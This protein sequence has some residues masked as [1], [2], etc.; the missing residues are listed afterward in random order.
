MTIKLT[1]TMGPSRRKRVLDGVPIVRGLYAHKAPDRSKKSGLLNITHSDSGLSIMQYIP[2]DFLPMVIEQLSK[3]EWAVPSGTI[4]SSNKHFNLIRRTIQMLTS[5]QRSDKQENRIAED[6]QGKRQPASGSR[7]GYRRDVITPSFLVEAKTTE[8]TSYRL[9]DKDLAFLRDQAYEKGKIPVYI[10][11]LKGKSEVAVVPTDDVD[12][13]CLKAG[14]NKQISK[15]E[16]KS[17]SINLNTAQFVSDGGSITVTLPSGDYTVVG[18]EQF[19]EMAKVG[20]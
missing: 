15:K 3:L 2:S 4:Y 18:Y 5:K 14:L 12:P 20:V 13:A 7:W 9:E 8:T 17:F 1:I 11:E 10:V 6:L 16:S 19:L